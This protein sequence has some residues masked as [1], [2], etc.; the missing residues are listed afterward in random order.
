MPEPGGDGSQYLALMP[1]SDRKLL[2]QPGLSLRDIWIR[3]TQKGRDVIHMMVKAGQR[4]LAAHQSALDEW[5]VANYVRL[6]DGK[7]ARKPRTPKANAP[8]PSPFD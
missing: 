3:M 4:E 1:Q 7:L 8:K 2:T 5:T 6:P